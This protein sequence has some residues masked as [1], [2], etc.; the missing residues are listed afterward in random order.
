ML[1]WLAV[2]AWQVRID[3]SDS[4]GAI[5]NAQY[6]IGLTDR[7][8]GQ[9]GPLMAFLLA[10]AEWV[11]NILDL[12][13]LD[14]RPHHATLAL[15]HAVYISVLAFVLVRSYGRHVST[16]IGF[17]I[18][19][20]TFIFF[21]Y[22]PFISH[23]IF[24]GMLF[25]A[26]LL[27]AED[28]VAKPRLS[29]W[30]LLV[31]SGTLVALIKHTYAIC[32]AVVLLVRILPFFVPT[33]LAISPFRTVIYLSVGA[34]F[35]AVATWLVYAWVLK[36]W[37]PDIDFILRPYYQIISI[38]Q[39]FARDSSI[40]Y[41]WWFY[42]RNYPVGY[43]MVNAV[44]MLAAVYAALA[45]RRRLM[46]SVALAWLVSFAVMHGLSFYE[47]RYL[48]Y[49]APLG[50]FMM[51]PFLRFVWLR[52]RHWIRFLLFLLV[53]DVARAGL[54]ASR[55]FDP[56]YSSNPFRQFLAPIEQR[57]GPV[58]IARDISFAPNRHSPLVAD[59]Y[60]R[61][62][63]MPPAAIERLYN[64][65]SDE[66]RYILPPQFPV[67]VPLTR[68]ERFGEGAVVFY[69]NTILI[70]E[71][72]LRPTPPVSVTG[73]FVQLSAVVEL[74]PYEREAD[75]FVLQ[76]S[77]NR[78]MRFD[79]DPLNETLSIRPIPRSVSAAEGTEDH[80]RQWGYRVIALC[81]DSVCSKG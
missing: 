48:A 41:P 13:P 12:H 50:A 11:A 6:L 58:V 15:V 52:R 33:R 47:T 17:M 53:I 3:Y 38:P 81:T 69:A 68:P 46:Q 78:H 2:A 5:S 62:F 73:Q 43:G 44:L 23:D 80:V 55:V 54:E 64:I 28:F 27:L 14:I 56:F 9:R 25:L 66:M 61:I 26:M 29:I 51:V 19:I 59:R 7:Y 24:P 45:S 1:A 39:A 75:R 77:G 34:A 21:S 71:V 65:P 57:K 22:A 31:V 72:E 49:L 18:T 10:P 40:E 32:W 42:L 74:V 60:H 36:G 37:A 30:L 4:Y 70:R 16:T 35:S 76:P 20:P 67:P 79:Y 8:F 63:H